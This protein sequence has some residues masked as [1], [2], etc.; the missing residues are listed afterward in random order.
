MKEKLNK[1][2]AKGAVS[3][4]DAFLR[5]DAASATGNTLGVMGNYTP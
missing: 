4:L 2:V 5:A 3:V 1:R